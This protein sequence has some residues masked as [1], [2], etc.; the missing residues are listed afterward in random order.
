MKCILFLCIIA[1]CSLL[2]GQDLLPE[3]TNYSFGGSQNWSVDTDQNGVVYV[4]N[5]S[6]LSSY[7][8]QFWS[9]HALPQNTIIRSVLCVGNRIY[10]GSYEDF[11]F[12]EKDHIGQLTYH[13]LRSKF[14]GEGPVQSEEFWQ[15]IEF[16]NRIIFRSFGA[17]YAYDGKKIEKIV[18]NYTVTSLTVY[19]NRLLFGSLGNGVMEI[20]DNEVRPFLYNQ[21]LED[22]DEIS[23]ISSHGG[24]LFINDIEKGG[25]FFD[26]DQVLPLTNSVQRAISE[27][28]LNT[29]AFV[30]EEMIVF[31][32]VK[33]GIL[34][35]N[36]TSGSFDIINKQAGL[37][38]NTVLEMKIDGDY[39]WLALDNGTCRININSAYK[40]FNDATGVLGTVY[41]IAFF[42][43]SYYLASNTGIYTF[44]ENGLKLIRNSEGHCWSLTLFEDF[45]LCG[46][47]RG[48]FILDGENLSPVNGSFSGVYSFTPIPNS[49]KLLISTYSGLGLL[50]TDNN[51]PSISKLEGLDVPVNKALF[52]NDS[53]IW[54]SGYYKDLFKVNFNP[55]EFLIRDI[56]RLSENLALD[57]FKVDVEIINQKPY[58]ISG[59]NWYNQKG[60]ETILKKVES[61]SEQVFLNNTSSGLWTRDERVSSFNNYDHHL[62]IKKSKDF[63]PRLAKRFVSGH[64]K[65]ILKNDST[66]LFNLTDG[67]ASLNLEKDDTQIKSTPIISKIFLDK[68]LI[69]LPKNDILKLTHQEARMI[70]FE[71]FVPNAYE[72]LLEFELTGKQQFNETIESGKF[73][74]QNLPTG[75]YKLHINQK[76]SLVNKSTITLLVAPPWYYSNYMIV[77]YIVIF[78]IILF[79]VG[80]FQKRKAEKSHFMEQERLKEE[81]KQRIEDLEKKNLINEVKAKRKELTNSTA[82]VVQK[83]ETIISL[84]NELKRLEKVSPNTLRT[85]NILHRSGEQLDSKNDW[86]LFESRFNELNEDFFKSL[87]Q[88]FPKLTTKDRKLC[89]YI[90][91]GLT[92]K[93]I[94][95]LL[96]ITKRSV[97]LQ[98]YRLRKK[99]NLDTNISF[100]EFLDRF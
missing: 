23:L 20:A 39:L 49:N 3:I 97:E 91:I 1:T 98:R 14:Q 83:N 48:A 86:T 32:T 61:M 60:D 44:N 58:L 17:I 92:S 19:K 77:V 6:G 18:E 90:K 70:E 2:Q 43:N 69:E 54:V 8:G 71:V 55:N 40:F 88:A 28:S 13:S 35:H 41:D 96:G 42:K 7:N 50:H 73:A 82:A 85:K 45:L 99:L 79:L 56:N 93:E 37:N 38:N 11:G 84:R 94:A 65:V 29:A 36:I 4:A 30:S 75:A 57:E 12:W 53:I 78:L 68:K 80:K 27:F 26:G 24:I 51:S 33:N 95:P 74:L 46:H 47:N 67:F 31:G 81:A 10:T 34:L 52:E 100:T 63:N 59:S 25:Y 76:N 9:L 72:S 15:I 5:N 16:D 64:E 89:A 66:L 21:K 87:S 62:N 22:L